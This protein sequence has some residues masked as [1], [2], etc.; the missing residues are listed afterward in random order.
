LSLLTV[1]GV[2]SGYGKLEVLHDVSVAV[3]RGQLVTLLG[4]NGAGKSTLLKSIYGLLRL[5]SGEIRY[6]G[7]QI[8]GTSPVNVA[9]QGLAL[10]PQGVGVF[11]K[12]SVRD[13]LRLGFWNN[14]EKQKDRAADEDFA[15]ALE[16]FPALWDRLDEPAGRLSGG[17]RQMVSISRALLAMPSM[18]LLDEPSVGLAPVIVEQVLRVLRTLAD[19]GMAIML[20][21]QN[22]RQSLSVSDYT[23]VLKSGRIVLDSPPQE[24]DSPERLWELF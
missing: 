6:D 20:V 15:P 4:H 13:N 21:E 7:R 18:L 22:V 10:V 5:R 17:Q 14:R 23:Y 12:L 24:I 8:S 3:E 2:R 11:S 1:R 16:H 19:G 9:A